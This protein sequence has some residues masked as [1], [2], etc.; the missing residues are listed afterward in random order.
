MGRRTSLLGLVLGLGMMGGTPA[1]PALP[2]PD[3]IVIVVEE[4]KLYSRIIGNPEAPYINS[5]AARGAARPAL[6]TSPAVLENLTAAEGLEQARR[7]SCGK[8]MAH[9]RCRS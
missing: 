2:R 5:L 1:R 9:G 6:S 4:N 3:H 8:S 7:T